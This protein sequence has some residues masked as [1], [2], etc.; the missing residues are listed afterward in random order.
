MIF[1][2]YIYPLSRFLLKTL[3]GCTLVGGQE[4]MD[5]LCCVRLTQSAVIG[6][7]SVSPTT[8]LLLVRSCAGPAPI[9]D[10]RAIAEYVRHA[11]RQR[12]HCPLQEGVFREFSCLAM[13]R[14]N[15]GDVNP[16]VCNSFS[17]A[18]IMKS[19]KT[20]LDSASEL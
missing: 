8:Q 7:S 14:G 12:V 17:L 10:S 20:L 11:M 2:R 19:K 5:A 16:S 15:N 9:A 3:C 1:H 18:V 6:R 13:F 4:G